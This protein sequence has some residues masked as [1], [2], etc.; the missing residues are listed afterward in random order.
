MN[1]AST[2]SVILAIVSTS[3]YI[4]IAVKV[5]K[6][7]RCMYKIHNSVLTCTPYVLLPCLVC[8]MYDVHYMYKWC[9]RFMQCMY[10]A[11]SKQASSFS[12]QFKCS[13]YWVHTLCIS[14]L[15][16]KRPSS[17]FQINESIHSNHHGFSFAPLPLPLRTWTILIWMD[18]Y[19]GYLWISMDI[20]G[21]IWAS[22]RTF[23]TCWTGLDIHPEYP[24]ISIHIHPYPSKIFR[25]IHILYP[26]IISLH[27]P[28]YY[29]SRYP[30]FHFAYPCVFKW[31]LH[32]RY[33][34]ISI[35][36]IHV[37]TTYISK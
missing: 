37:L 14:I 31:E 24:S 35:Q 18:M 27:H 16:W 11:F 2:Y 19:V 20:Y 33:T 23:P 10:R 22:S 28:C 7:I 5:Q 17:M 32:L 13:L 21:Y 3:Q 9:T 15:H 12:E 29:P 34:Y 36:Y 25:D 6:Y 1:R 26:K 30:L 8:T 4:L